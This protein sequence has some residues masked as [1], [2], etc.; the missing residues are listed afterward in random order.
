[1]CILLFWLRLNIISYIWE[2]FTYYPVSHRVMISICFPMGILFLVKFFKGLVMLGS[3]LEMWILKTFPQIFIC[4][5]ISAPC[6][7]FS[8]SFFVDISSS[9]LSVV[10]PGFHSHLWKLFSLAVYKEIRLFILLFWHS[11]FWHLHFWIYLQFI[12][13]YEVS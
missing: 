9:P 3:F 8:F 4:F 12:L 10:A 6:I 5:I 13:V 2:K 11:I 1:M 7:L